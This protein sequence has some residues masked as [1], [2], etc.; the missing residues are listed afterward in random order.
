MSDTRRLQISLLVL[1][2]SIGVFFLVWSVEKLIAPEVTQR[3][4]STFYF[5]PLPVWI[6]YVVG[7]V[8][9][10]IV[11]VF[12]TGFLKTWTYGALLGMHSVSVLSTYERL[13]NPYEPPNHLFWAGVPA[14]GALLTL[15]LLRN[16]DRLF[17]IAVNLSTGQNLKNKAEKGFHEK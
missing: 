8:Q 13:I 12:M 11:L 5:L 1:R 2:I 6:S 3:V 9:T 15:F 4:F 17:S 7:V 10:L 14:W 16:S